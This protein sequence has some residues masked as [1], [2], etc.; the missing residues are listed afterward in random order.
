MK[1]LLI[2]ISLI[3][4][5]FLFLNIALAQQEKLATPSINL[6]NS[7]SLQINDKT[8]QS[9]KE[10]IATKV[11]QLYQQNKKIVSGII[12]KKSQGIIELTS[13]DNI[14]Y[15]ITIDELLTK[16]S[17]LLNNT[18]KEIKKEDLNENDF[19]IVVGTLIDNSINAKSIY[20]DQQYLVYSGKVIEVNKNDYSLK[21]LTSEKDEYIID[22]EVSTKQQ[23]LDIKKLTL[24]P[25][26]FSKIK[27][28]DTIHFVG[29]KP[30]EKKVYRFS[31]TRILIIPQEYFSL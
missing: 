4:G 18:Q 11:A 19:V 6:K 22:I 1:K 28:G 31:A 8:I 30:K 9:L 27:E 3:L 24:D 20:Q 15:K 29:K 16:F 21:I 2:V 14:S 13:E 26:G 12:T 7:S 23:I 25:C 17:S 5:F 10:K